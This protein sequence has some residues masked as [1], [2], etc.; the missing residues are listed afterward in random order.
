M[1]FIAFC[2]HCLNI[3]RGHGKKV[4]HQMIAEMKEAGVQPSERQ[5][6]EESRR[7]LAPGQRNSGHWDS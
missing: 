2:A 4:N 6:V 7:N 3:N 5:S 1:S